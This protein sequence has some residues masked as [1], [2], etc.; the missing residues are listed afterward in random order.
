MIH[1]N[2]LPDE[3]PTVEEI[4][5]FLERLKHSLSKDGEEWLDVRLQVREGD[6]GISWKIWEGDAQYDWDHRGYWGVGSVGLE[7]DCKQMAEWMIGQCLEQLA[8]SE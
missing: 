3:W 5:S 1:K 4:V 7:V 2:E 6:Y 8:M